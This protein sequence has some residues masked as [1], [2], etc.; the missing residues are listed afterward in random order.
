VLLGFLGR[1]EMVA[2]G[3]AASEVYRSRAGDAVRPALDIQAVEPGV[4]RSR[5]SAGEI[6]QRPIVQQ[7]RWLT[8]E[9]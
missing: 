6:H 8:S 3:T 2:V 9:S 4:R 5:L 7:D 1:H